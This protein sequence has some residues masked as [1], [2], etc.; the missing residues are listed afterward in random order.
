MAMP[1][2]FRDRMVRMKGK[3]EQFIRDVEW[4]NKN[5]T[6]APPMDCEPERVAVSVCDQA[7][8][9]FDAGDDP[10]F[11]ELTK[12]LELVARSALEE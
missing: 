6:D 8:A 5:R 2:R 10:R 12:E 1:Q 4:W 11:S 7:L 9:A 3:F